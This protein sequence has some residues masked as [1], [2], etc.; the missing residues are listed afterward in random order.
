MDLNNI[1]FDDMND[2]ELELFESKMDKWQDD[3]VLLD[4]PG[5]VNDEAGIFMCCYCEQVFSIH[6]MAVGTVVGHAACRVC[7]FR[8]TM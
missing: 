7:H 2:E 8:E 5:C 1:D 4:S 3:E 6:F